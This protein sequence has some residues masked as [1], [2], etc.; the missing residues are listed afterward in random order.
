VLCI[1]FSGGSDLFMNDFV[2]EVEYVKYSELEKDI[3]K[4]SDY[5]VFGKDSSNEYNLYI[6]HLGDKNKPK[7]LITSNVHGVEWH[8]ASYSLKGMKMIDDETHP[9][10]DMMNRLLNNFHVLYVPVLNPWGYDNVNDIYAQ[11][12]NIHYKNYNNVDINRD[13]EDVTQIETKNMINV[14]KKYKPF[15]HM[16]LHTFQ[17]EYQLANQ[18]IVIGNERDDTVIYQNRLSDMIESYTNQ[19]VH[20]WKKQPL[21]DK[22]VRGYT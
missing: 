15:A 9:Y 4:F 1:K 13:F 21:R 3:R 14:M 19:K 11:F 12:E 16:D 7:I 20:Q 8:T 18:N 10:K 2:G 17:S 22:M 5:E 6:I